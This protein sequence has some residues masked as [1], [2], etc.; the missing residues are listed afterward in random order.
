MAPLSS[1]TIIDQTGILRPRNEEGMVATVN[2]SGMCKIQAISRYMH[3]WKV[4]R[5]WRLFSSQKIII[6]LKLKNFRCRCKEKQLERDISTKN[7]SNN[8]SS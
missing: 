3:V 5:L 7:N 6:I 2:C 8:K 4:M 1:V